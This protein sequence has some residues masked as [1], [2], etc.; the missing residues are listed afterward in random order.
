MPAGDRRVPAPET[1]ATHTTKATK[2]LGLLV[3]RGYDLDTAYAAVR[4]FSA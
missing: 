1:G 4:A 3:R 2:A